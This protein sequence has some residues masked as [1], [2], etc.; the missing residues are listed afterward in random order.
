MFLTRTP[1]CKIT[2]LNGY[3]DYWP[4]WEVSVSELPLTPATDMSNKG[5]NRKYVII[6][7]GGVRV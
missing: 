4:E 2:H 5:M 3:Y 1:C 7:P 6:M